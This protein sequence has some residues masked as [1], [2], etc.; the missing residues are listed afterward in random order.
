MN[1]LHAASSFWR[2]LE[3][4]RI[5]LLATGLCLSLAMTVL[6]AARPIFFEYLDIKLYDTV[7]RQV[8]DK[9]TSGVPIVVDIDEASLLELGQWPWPRYRMA[10]L[11][12]AIKNLGAE[13]V[14][15]DMVF[16]E[17]DRTSLAVL[18]DE[19]AS[20]HNVRLSFQG[21]PEHLLDNDAA[22]AA[23]LAAGP[24]V[25]GYH[26]NF[27]RTAGSRAQQ[28]ELHKLNL[29]ILRGPD[30]PAPEN[31]LFNAPAVVCNL[32][33]LGKAV[34][35]SGFFNALPDPDGIIRHA[36]L[37]IEHEGRF[38]PNLALAAY[39]QAR[40]SKQLILWLKR[41][42]SA[43]QEPPSLQIGEDLVVPLTGKGQMTINFHG[44]RRT[45]PYYS[46]AD[47]LAGR[48]PE[49]EFAGRV[50]F[51]GTSAAGLK[52]IRAT[53]LDQVYPGV[54]VHAT[55]LDNLIQGDFL[56][57]PEIIDDIEVALVL[58]M[59]LLSTALLVW[60]GA[61]LSLVPLGLCTAGLWYGSYW[62]FDNEGMFVSPLI[63]TLT[64]AANF[65]L[66]TLLKFFREEGQKR[67]FH[68]A[69]SQYVSRAVVEQIVKSP[70]KLS[71]SGEE[72]EVSILFSD[73]RSFTSMSE[74]L[75]PNQVSELLQAY[76]TP[77]TA[78]I[79]ARDG[80]LDK[81]IGDAIMAFWNAPL[82]T[83]DH[84]RKAVQSALGMHAALKQLNVQFKERFNLELQ[85][86]V[87][88][89]SGLVRVGNMGSKDLFDYT[90][91]GDSVNLASRLEGLT[92]FY[93]LGIVASESIRNACGDTELFFQEVD[94]VRVKGKALPIVIYAPYSSE[95]QAIYAEELQLHEKA[96]RRYKAQ[97]FESAME[98]FSV[99]RKDYRDLRLYAVYQDRC[100]QLQQSPP[101]EGWDHVYTHS[102][103]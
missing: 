42:D 3:R 75:S 100:L 10:R 32:D 64:L 63:P 12:T 91:I 51:I 88:L 57:E 92:K 38:Y 86:G 76:F 23:A 19:L 22:L 69:F 14:A 27:E 60:T 1:I 52:D 20:E 66:L 45:F 61:L 8:H 70:E 41:N 62:V 72:R 93:G 80:T 9:K 54:E 40:P 83:S 11:L 77:M 25:L 28:C 85:I 65:A 49:G 2:R 33:V 53:P 101:G 68:Q 43:G 36:P 55:V 16:S 26:F 98:L 5:V 30:S 82:D 58:G 95:D 99:L 97:D 84:Q 87:G 81:F 103:K 35:R 39:L 7:L 48:I 47:V 29:S 50:A 24:F 102:S 56:R 78:E 44:P 89:H 15:L 21:L 59:G 79:I 90:I 94:T 18:R 4:G 6:Y 71:L 13:A 67:F 74:Q 46:A 37:I 17:P 31:V 34:S 73:I 96:M